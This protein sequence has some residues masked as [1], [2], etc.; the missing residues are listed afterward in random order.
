MNASFLFLVLLFISSYAQALTYDGVFQ[1]GGFMIATTQPDAHVL[2]EKQTMKVD[3]NGRFIVPFDRHQPPKTFLD[4]TLP[5]GSTERYEITVKQREY[6]TQNV[7]GVKKKHVH[8]NQKQINVSRN[9][10]QRIRQAR[11]HFEQMPYIFDKFKTPVTGPLTG[12]YGSKRLYNGVERT[13]H[14]GIDIAAPTGTP[15]IAPAAGKVRLALENSFF[16]GN[17]VVIDHGHS[18][19]TV[20]AHMDSIA[21]KNSQFL[22]RGDLIGT[23]GST[24]RS[25]GPHLHWG[26]YWR[27][28]ALDPA[29]WLQEIEKGQT[30]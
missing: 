9:D 6:Q 4:L 28:I 15:I 26:L 21:V 19:T 20:Y 13:W 25:T 29:L 11:T 7:T 16:N 3:E 12:V 17:L 27:N 18:M 5:D 30:R 23:V 24:G 2:W 1:Q 14:K 10:A 8:P 22:N